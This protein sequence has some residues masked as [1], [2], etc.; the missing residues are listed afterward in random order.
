M[1][2]MTLD[3][4]ASLVYTTPR[5]QSLLMGTTQACIMKEIMCSSCQTTIVAYR[6]KEC[7]SATRAGAHGPKQFGI[8]HN[9]RK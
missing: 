1:T 5:G 3:Y 2:S 8:V 7:Y 6:Y 4:P 9:E